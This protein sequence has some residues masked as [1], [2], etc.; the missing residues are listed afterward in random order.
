MIL[1]AGGQLDP[2]IGALLRCVL[3]RGAP[4]RDLL[5]GPDLRPRLRIDLDGGLQLNGEAIEPGACFVRHDV[6][7]PQRTGRVEDQR[8]ALN[9]YQAVRGWAAS[10]PSVR[11]LNRRSRGADPNKYDNLIR[12]MRLGLA[13]PSTLIATDPDLDGS[14]PSIRKPVA[15]GELTEI[16]DPLQANLPYPFFIQPQLQRPEL[17]VYRVGDE[18]F[19]FTLESP[20]LDYRARQKV[21]LSVYEPPAAISSRL[22]ALCEDLGLD[23]AAADFMR[24]DDGDWS[25]LEVNAQPMFAAFDRAASG[26]LCDAIVSWLLQDKVPT[27]NAPF[28]EASAAT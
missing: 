13:V 18:M 5:V 28:E 26:R 19:G 17:R 21:E 16:A 11:L 27:P 24:D 25:F 10:Q 7:L 14:T 12:A 15:G 4:F 3:R 2:N 8:A 6:F 20:D 22:Y 23:F 1:V 9:W